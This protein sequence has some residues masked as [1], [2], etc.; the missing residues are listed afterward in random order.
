MK[1]PPKNF[2]TMPGYASMA[3]D[4]KDLRELLLETSGWII[5]CGTIYDIKN[6]SLGA[7]VYKV[8]L[9]GRY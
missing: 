6:E 5:A 1:A 4:N 3:M 9:K 8:F 2:Y 7:G